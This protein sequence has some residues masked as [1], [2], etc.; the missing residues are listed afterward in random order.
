MF[1]EALEHRILPK[2]MARPVL[3]KRQ[4]IDY[5][6]E[7]MSL[8]AKFE[9]GDAVELQGI[10]GDQSLIWVLVGLLLPLLLS[11]ILDV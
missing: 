11:T 10:R 6:R 3:T 1:D 9:V 5:W 4:Y 2:S 7:V 8:F